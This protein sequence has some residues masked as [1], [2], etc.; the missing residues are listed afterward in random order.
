MSHRFHKRLPPGGLTLVELLVV[1]AVLVVLVTLLLPGLQAA[2]ES[3]R[4][5]RCAGNL[6]QIGIAYHHFLATG[7]LAKLVPNVWIEQL[8]MFAEHSDDTWLCPSVDPAEGFGEAEGALHVRNRGFADYGGSHDIPFDKSGV[9]CR[10]WRQASRTVAGSYGLEFE[11]HVDWDWNDLRMLVEPLPDG[12][13]R[14]TAVSKS[15]AFT[16]DIKDAFGAVVASDFK[17]P[18]VVVLPGG[19]RSHYAVNGRCHLMLA[20]DIA[21]ILCL[22]YRG[23][24]VADVVGPLAK[25]YWPDLVGDRHFETVNALFVDGHVEALLPEGIDPRSAPLHELFWRPCRDRLGRF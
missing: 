17:P 25:D 9:R 10:E 13:F 12:D 20:N 7:G 3:A 18:K 15:A 5:T 23:K 6:R 21:K 1:I 2:R 16:F 8:G 19:G 11:D 14:L 24:T 4:R 22:E